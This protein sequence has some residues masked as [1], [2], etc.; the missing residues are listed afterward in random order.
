MAPFSN[1]FGKFQPKRSFGIVA[2]AMPLAARYDVATDTTPLTRGTV[3]SDFF[4]F[5]DSKEN[6]DPQ[7]G[8]QTSARRIAGSPLTPG[9]EAAAARD[10]AMTATTP[11]ACAQ[12]LEHATLCLP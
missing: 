6:L 10:A 8:H 3:P 1:R 2:S 4:V 5:S 12:R 7:N 11:G 9:A